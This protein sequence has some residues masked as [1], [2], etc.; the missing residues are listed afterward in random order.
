MPYLFSYQNNNIKIFM[1]VVK[2]TQKF[3]LYKK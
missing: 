1:Y 3:N 2:N